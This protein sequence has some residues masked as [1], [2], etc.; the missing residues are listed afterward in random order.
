MIKKIIKTLVVCLFVMNLSYS[1]ADFAEHYNLAQDYLSQFQYSSA[2]TEFKKAL[3]INYMDNSA[4]IG[5]VNSYLARGT[6]FANTEKNWSSAANDFRAALFYL[7]YYPSAQDAQNSM[8][9]ISTATQNL[10]QCLSAINY[11]KTPAKRY[12]KGRELRLQGMFA[13]AGYEFAQSANDVAFK[14]EAYEQM[15][16]LL[17]VL[18]NDT[19]AAEYYKKAIELN[20]TSASLRMKYARVLDRLGQNNDA[21]DA[22]NY[23]LSNGTKDPEIMYALERIYRQKLAN[24][25]ND[26]A[27]LTN[28]GAILQKQNKLDEALQCYSKASAIDERNITTKLN[29]GTLYQQKKN[30]QAAI[31]AYDSVLLL[32]PNHKEANLYKAQCLAASGDKQAAAVAFENALKSDSTNKN[33]KL[34]VFESLKDTL[35][36]NEIISYIYK[37]S[38]P[39]KMVLDEMYDYAIDLHKQKIY[40]R[41]IPFYQEVLKYNSNNPEVYVNLAIATKENGDSEKAKSILANAKK[42]FPANTQ[43][44]STLDNFT[45]E[46]LNTIYTK[47]SKLFDG[48][49][50]NGAMAVYKEV[51]PATFDSLTGM[52]ACYKALNNDNS[53]I[54]YYKKALAIKKDSEVAYYLGVLY[55]DKED[56]GAAKNYLKQ[57][58]QI[59]P[60]N[61]DAKDLLGSVVEQVNVKVLDDAINAYE[62]KNNT[63]A[64]NLISQ[65]LSD[66][67][68]NPYAHYYRGLIYDEQKKFAQAVLDYK[69]AAQNAQELTICYYLMAIDYES[70]KQF[71]NALI[72]YKKYVSVTP[73]SN[74]YKT[75]S[76]SRI[77]ALKI[78]EK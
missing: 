77:K 56:W 19:K 30:Y 12:E 60:K 68:K 37:D 67:S 47:A 22:Y 7:R 33:L 44:S 65:V 76:L 11:D 70:L 35:A 54:E 63:R 18:G 73:E 71:K 8:Q 57:A 38:M 45:N 16:D 39:D 74:E 43:I 69:I 66:D 53:A 20:P 5:L 6:Y 42:I 72:N 32:Y 75:Y 15:A 46:A 1:K 23:A 78:Y 51:Q 62:A 50:I 59:N 58:L 25:E 55:A 36:P 9:S 41:A 52:A 49:D 28:L 64:L 29:V 31:Q 10:N 61:Q 48:G 26:A 21:L 27:T 2:I 24:N 14:K 4:R 34:Q 13:E 3:R 17:K 40:S